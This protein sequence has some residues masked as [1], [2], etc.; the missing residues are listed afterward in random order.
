MMGVS[1]TAEH[2]DDTDL[3]EHQEQ[4]YSLYGETPGLYSTIHCCGH[5]ENST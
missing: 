2:V 3:E 1:H 5:M 4:I